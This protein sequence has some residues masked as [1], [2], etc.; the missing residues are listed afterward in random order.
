MTQPRREVRQRVPD[1]GRPGEPETALG[2][3]AIEGGEGLDGA[4]GSISLTDTTFPRGHP[5]CVAVG[6]ERS[7]Q[8]RHGAL[9]RLAGGGR[10]TEAADLAVDLAVGGG[11]AGINGATRSAWRST[12]APWLLWTVTA[13]PAVVET[14]HEACRKDIYLR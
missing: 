7:A 8:R 6:A 4:H 10:A 13:P 9:R 12:V 3:I 2:E 1:V 11:I 5:S 14:R